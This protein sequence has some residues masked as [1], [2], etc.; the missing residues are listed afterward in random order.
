[1]RKKIPFSTKK[2]SPARSVRRVYGAKVWCSGR[3]GTSHYLK[4]LGSWCTQ[5]WVPF[6][7][8]PLPSNMR[9]KLSCLLPLNPSIFVSASILLPFCRE[10]NPGLTE[11]GVH[12]QVYLRYRE[13]KEG[14]KLSSS[15]PT[16]L[17]L[18][19]REDVGVSRPLALSISGESGGQ[20]VC[21]RCQ[22]PKAP[23]P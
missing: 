2:S 23:I 6:L 11:Q 9:L 16:C 10:S 7:L 14:G 15:T 5:F 19:P 18:S 21:L 12:S 17:S 8:L 1:M 4:G 20:E 13:V 22:Y 3:D